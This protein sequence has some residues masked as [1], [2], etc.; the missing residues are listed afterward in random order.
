MQAANYSIK[1]CYQSTNNNCSQTALSILLSY[2]DIAKQM[3]AEEIMQQIPVNKDEKGEDWGTI[4][5]QLATWCIGQG[6]AVEL[7]TFDCQAIDLSWADLDQ[8]QLL[9]R[10]EA[11]KPVRDV[12]SL[13]RQWSEIY[14]RSYAD[15]VKAGGQLFI[16]PYVTTVLLYELLKRGPILL[17][18][19][20]NT[21][22]NKG[23]STYPGVREIVPDDVN[24]KVTNH[25]IVIFGITEKGDFE[26]AD[27]WE[28]PGFHT[29]DPERMLCAITA[30]QIECDNLLF[31]LT[32]R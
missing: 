14:L 32:V 16:K 26:I 5:Q 17:C 9:A 20:F 6:F 1:H 18:V 11:T 10:I 4:N 31:Q 15:F 29:I 19:C 24:G 8:D 12:P 28:K 22:H 30:A 25:T 3:S 2:Y 23:R 13:G 21:L 7:Y 27:P